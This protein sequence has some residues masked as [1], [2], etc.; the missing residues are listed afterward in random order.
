MMSVE[1]GDR[2]GKD[3]KKSEWKGLKVVSDNQI[4]NAGNKYT[5]KP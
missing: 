5:L 1:G 4:G 2:G 3:N